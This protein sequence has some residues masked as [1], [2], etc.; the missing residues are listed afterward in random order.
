MDAVQLESFVSTQQIGPDNAKVNAVTVSASKKDGSYNI[1]LTNADL[2]ESRK[3]TIKMDGVEKLSS[4]S[5][6]CLCGKKMNS[7]NTF[8]NPDEVVEKECEV[9]VNNNLVEITLPERSVV[10]IT[11]K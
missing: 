8:D 7:M 11:V 2:K 4:A 1:T 10:S 9:T 3:I 6:K 5:A